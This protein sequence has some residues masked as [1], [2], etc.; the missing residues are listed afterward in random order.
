MLVLNSRMGFELFILGFDNGEAAEIPVQSIRQV[1]G[2]FWVDSPPYD[3]R[4]NYDD[5][6]LTTVSFLR[7]RTDKDRITGF[8]IESPG[9]DPR[10]WD[11]LAA[12]LRLGQL[13]IIYG[14]GPPLIASLG[15]ADHLP[16][17]LLES[18]GAPTCVRSGA[19][20]VHAITGR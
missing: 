7:D 8:T 19:E 3:G 1:F 12:I 10:L 4:L 9:S 15:L 5:P 16:S 6:N 13:A 20:I 14:D 17:E 11:A 2:E 18:T